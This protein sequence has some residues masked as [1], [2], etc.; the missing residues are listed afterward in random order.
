ML[1]LVALVARDEQ[2]GRGAG[3]A[4]LIRAKYCV[5]THSAVR[6][7][8]AAVAP[9]GGVARFFSDSGFVARLAHGMWPAIGRFDADLAALDLE[10][11]LSASACYSPSGAYGARPG[12]RPIGVLLGADG[13]ELCNGLN[14]CNIPVGDDGYVQSYL[15]SKAQ[16]VVGQIRNQAW[17]PRLR[18]RRVVR[19]VLLVVAPVGLL[20]DARAPTRLAPTLR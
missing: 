8:N 1:V 20:G 14:V 13:G 5:T 11:R 10:F 15:S 19:A 17:A 18:Q 16:G 2:Q 6:R 9:A 12:V 4:A 3:R 7:L